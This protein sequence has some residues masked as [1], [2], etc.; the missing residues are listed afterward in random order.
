MKKFMIFFLAVGILFMS[1]PS[2]ASYSEKNL[3]VA[4]RLKFADLAG[5]RI[6]FRSA[7]IIEVGIDAGT[8]LF[9]SQFGPYIQIHPKGQSDKAIRN[10]YLSGR[11]YRSG[12]FLVLDYATSFTSEFVIGYEFD[13]KKGG[14]YSFLE[15]GVNVNIGGWKS[16]LQIGSQDLI[17]YPVLGLG[18]GFKNELRK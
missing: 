2:A 15:A 12:Y 11:L 1:L 17:W 5:G 10:C 4:A 7:N 14:F 9:V 18:F 13:R 3:N 8:S 6:G 16:T